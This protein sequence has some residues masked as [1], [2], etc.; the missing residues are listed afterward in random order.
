MLWIRDVSV[1]IEK[2]YN[3]DKKTNC[4]RTHFIDERSVLP[5]AEFV[6]VEWKC[7]DWN[8]QPKFIAA[9][10]RNNRAGSIRNGYAYD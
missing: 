10:K 9:F 4:N 3:H 5:R 7:G 8:G 6:S 1:C 2:H